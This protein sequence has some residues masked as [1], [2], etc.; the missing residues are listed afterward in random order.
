MIKKISLMIALSLTAYGLAN[1]PGPDGRGEHGDEG[2]GS[3]GCSDLPCMSAS[4]RYRLDSGHGTPRGEF[5]RAS[6]EQSSSTVDTEQVTAALK[7]A[8]LRVAA[9]RSA[10]ENK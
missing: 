6:H 5:V 10:A 3:E 1:P 7:A 9:S 4:S 2:L 8:S